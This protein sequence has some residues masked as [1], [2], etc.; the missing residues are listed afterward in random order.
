MNDI[1]R[2]KVTH[3]PFDQ[4]QF[5]K[6]YENCVKSLDAIKVDSR[7]HPLVTEACILFQRQV[8][9]VLTHKSLAP[10]TKALLC[11]LIL[12]KR[13][14]WCILQ[15]HKLKNGE[16][17]YAKWLFDVFDRYGAECNKTLGATIKLY[18]EV[19]RQYGKFLEE[20]KH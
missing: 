6:L 9:P 18:A 15:M 12:A 17:R 8:E 10:F 3:Y 4:D 1:I 5:A 7:N 16:L 13:R 19:S 11:T 20:P 2:P 14:M